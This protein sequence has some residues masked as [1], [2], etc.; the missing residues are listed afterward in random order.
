M[1]LTAPISS[2]LLFAASLASLSGCATAPTQS[3]CTPPANASALSANPQTQ[4]IVLGE[5]HGTNEIPAATA[6]LVCASAQSGRVLL[7]LE[8]SSDEQP[9]LRE[10]VRGRTNEQQL[11][12]S[13]FWT[14]T[15]DGR[16]SNA[17]LAMLRRIRDLRS[18]G[19]DIEIAAVDLPRSLPSEER[20]RILRDAAL[21]P[22]LDPDPSFRDLYMAR[23]L[24]D[25]SEAT[26]SSIAY[27]LVGNLHA[28]REVY[29]R[30]F[31]HAPTGQVVRMRSVSAAAALPAKRTLTVLF[32]HAGGTAYAFS[33]TGAGVIRVAPTDGETPQLG[34]VPGPIPWGEHQY[35]MAVFVG[36]LT[37]SLPADD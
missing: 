16:S 28:I 33:N 14:E 19:L 3:R 36:P 25:E 10:F 5:Y 12:G 17:M 20:E 35:D 26:Q 24:R 37:A 2:L 30:E 11:T 9:N 7:A 21:P 15:R 32:T 31:L 8:T 13:S 1:A 27:F 23:R 4:F 18:S 29:D 6:E 22:D 34:V